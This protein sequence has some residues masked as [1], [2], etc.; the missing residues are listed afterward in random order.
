MSVFILRVTGEGK[1]TPRKQGR[2]GQ[3]RGRKGGERK[4][5]KRRE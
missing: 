1:R 5:G 2:G 3:E 4:R